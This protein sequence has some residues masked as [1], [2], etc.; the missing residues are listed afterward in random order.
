MPLTRVMWIEKKDGD[1][2]AGPARIGRVTFSKSRKSLHY[3]GKTFRTLDGQG[4]KANYADVDTGEEYWI[5]G[6]RKDGRDAL[7]STDVEIDEDVREEDWIDIR[8]LPDNVH[9]M[10]FRALGKYSV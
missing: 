1:G 3:G 5:S 10:A 6:C 9:V 4:F 2:L 7:Y 8:K